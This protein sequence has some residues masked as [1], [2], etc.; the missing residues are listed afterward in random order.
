VQVFVGYWVLGLPGLKMELVDQKVSLTL[1]G[2]PRR[3]WPLVQPAQV[4]QMGMLPV[5]FGQTGMCWKWADQIQ[6][7]YLIGPKIPQNQPV[8]SGLTSVQMVMR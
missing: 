8:G 7:W 3:D 2:L 4:G 1:A 6:N 5:Y